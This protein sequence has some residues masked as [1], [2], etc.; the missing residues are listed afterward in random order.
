MGVNITNRL[1]KFMLL[2]VGYGTYHT[3][4]LVPN[5]CQ[6]VRSCQYIDGVLLRFCCKSFRWRLNLAAQALC[7][8]LAC[9]PEFQNLLRKRLVPSSG[10]SNMIRR[11]YPDFIERIPSL[12]SSSS[13]QVKGH[14][15][16]WIL[17]RY[18]SPHPW[19]IH[20]S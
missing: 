5:W 8:C 11:P 3:R 19:S 20:S 6:N 16:Q 18:R 4:K 7:T 2:Q 15:E 9:K 14:L 10:S 1:R 13:T 12:S 17:G